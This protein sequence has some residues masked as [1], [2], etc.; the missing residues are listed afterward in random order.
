MK[1]FVHVFVGNDLASK[2]PQ[3]IILTTK[4]YYYG[5]GFQ[6]IIKCLQSRRNELGLTAER[7]DFSSFFA[8]VIMGITF[9]EIDLGKS[10]LAVSS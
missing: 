8:L 5:V 7:R 9:W 3:I 1:Y 6:E 4:S 10:D 2:R